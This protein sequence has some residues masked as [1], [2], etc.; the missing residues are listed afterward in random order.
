MPKRDCT[1]GRDSRDDR[2]AGDDN[3]ITERLRRHHEFLG[4]TLTLAEL[5]EQLAWATRERPG[6]TAL[7]EHVL[8][9]EA[10]STLEKRIARRIESSG[11]GER[12][13]LEAFEWSFQPPASG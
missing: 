7:L 11:P 1:S 5:D 2:R 4:L 10:A 13:A 6:A 12:K 3:R 8:G 9:A